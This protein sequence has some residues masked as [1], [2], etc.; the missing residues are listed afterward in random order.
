M[1]RLVFLAWLISRSTSKAKWPKNERRFLVF[2]GGGGI[3][4]R[5]ANSPSFC[6]AW[7]EMIEAISRNEG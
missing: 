4:G 3:L 5:M 6:F 7:F 2:D 1:G